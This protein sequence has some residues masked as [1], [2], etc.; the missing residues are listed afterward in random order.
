MLSGF[1]SREEFLC[2]KTLKR[3]QG[4][5]IHMIYDAVHRKMKLYMKMAEQD[6]LTIELEDYAGNLDDYK[7]CD[8]KP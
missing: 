6:I 1:C 8:S 7:K 4:G 3:R 5:K 2:M